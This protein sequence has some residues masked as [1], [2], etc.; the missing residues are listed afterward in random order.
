MNGLGFILGYAVTHDTRGA[1]IGGMTSS[2]VMGLVLAS[3]LAP[4]SVPATSSTATPVAPVVTATPSSSSQINLSWTDTPGAAAYNVRRGTT[5]GGE[6]SCPIAPNLSEPSY[7]DTG[8]YAN[9]TYYYVVDAVDANGN[10]IVSSQEVS[11]T[12]TQAMARRQALAQ[13]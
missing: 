13:R 3:A 5:S 7:S 8:L 12:P 9:T 2:P 1:L 11:A 6:S 4:R 10:V